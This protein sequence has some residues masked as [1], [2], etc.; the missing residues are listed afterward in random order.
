VAYSATQV[1]SPAITTVWYGLCANS[2]IIAG[3]YSVS[4]TY[5]AVTN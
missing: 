2:T 4:V 3:T 1:V 5:T